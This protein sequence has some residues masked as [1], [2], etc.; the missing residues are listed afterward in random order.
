MFTNLYIYIPAT[1]API[2]AGIAKIV[3][4]AAET[5]CEL[6]VVCAKSLQTLATPATVP[7]YS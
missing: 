7:V 5:V 3:E 2:T 6:P 4:V 1:Q